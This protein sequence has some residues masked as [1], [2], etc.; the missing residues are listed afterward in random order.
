MDS[1]VNVINMFRLGMGAYANRRKS[2]CQGGI[3][4]SGRESVQQQ[5]NKLQLERYFENH[6]N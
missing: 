3:S 2:G 5:F 6:Y 4:A 1:I